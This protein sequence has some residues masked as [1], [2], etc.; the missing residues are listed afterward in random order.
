MAN[1][2]EILR[3]VA[4]VEGKKD[5]DGIGKAFDAVGKA[6]E[7]ADPEAKKLIDDIE[8][9][10]KDKSAIQ[11]FVKLKAELTDTGTKLAGAKGE[12][13]RLRGEMGKSDTA[14]KGLQKSFNAAEKEVARLT[15]AQNK[16]SVELQKLTGALGKAG[17]DTNKLA[18]ADRR[19]NDEGQ[20]V[21][22]RMR[23]FASGAS[24]AGKGAKD[25][26]AGVEELGKKAKGAQTETDGLLGTLGKITVL[27][28]AVGVAMKGLQL[29]AGEFAGAV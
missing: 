19:L 15:T 16:Q 21:A 20:K 10:G 3:F 5:V 17:I 18:D 26:A 8:R 14:S 13:E 7:K 12:L 22:Q 28:A 1:R 2:D 24:A 6:A 27:A 23:D 29:G 25:A 11:A 4:E 9:I